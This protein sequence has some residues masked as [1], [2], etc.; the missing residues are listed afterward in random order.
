[1]KVL[2]MIRV[3]RAREILL[4]LGMMLLLPVVVTGKIILFSMAA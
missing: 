1:M 4:L 2:D 3:W